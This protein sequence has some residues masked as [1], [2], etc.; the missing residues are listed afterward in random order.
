MRV[1]FSICLFLLESQA[2]RRNAKRDICTVAS[3]NDPLVDDIPNILSALQQCGDTGHIVL[4][5]NQ[6]FKIRSPLD[7]SLCKRC[8]IDING[9]LKLS[10][11]W[12]YWEKQSAVSKLSKASNVIISSEG[13]TDIID[14][15]D[16]GWVRL[17]DV[18]VPERMPHLF[19][20]SDGSYQVHIR[21]LKIRYV[22]GTVFYMS[23]ESSAIRLYDVEIQSAAATGFSIENAQH[24]YIWNNILRATGS[25]ITIAP[26]AA[27]VQV[28]DVRC[29][30]YVLKDTPPSGI[31]LTVSNSGALHWIRNIFVKN[32]EAIGW[33]NVVIF[34]T[35]PENL[36]PQSL[37]TNSATFTDI[38]H[39][40]SARQAVELV[41]SSAPLTATDVTFSNFRG[42]VQYDSELKCAI[43]RDVCDIKKEEWNTTIRA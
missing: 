29:F 16:F 34:S 15:N 7:L 35:V 11:D 23:S 13:N 40:D 18:P 19:S 41:S 33:M 1:L 12:D 6:T 10:Q 42:T 3:R 32:F 26:N 22:P 37:E 20:I 30:T 17:P 39:G 36:A 14:A 43:E 21:N 2:L 8:G 9:I 28:E 31:R 38:D 27:N 25:C 5:A 4:P 24:V